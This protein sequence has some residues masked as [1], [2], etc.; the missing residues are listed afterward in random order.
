MGYQHRVLKSTCGHCKKTF[1]WVDRELRRFPQQWTCKQCGAINSQKLPD[2]KPNVPPFLFIGPE[3]LARFKVYAT[4]PEH[5]NIAAEW[6]PPWSIRSF[7]KQASG[8]FQGC[9]FWSQ[10]R[11]TVLGEPVFRDTCRP[12]DS[13]IDHDDEGND[14]HLVSGWST[15]IDTCPLW[16]R[17]KKLCQTD[18]EQRFFH[19]YL[20]FVKDRQFPMLIPQARIGVAERRRPDF[21]LFVPLQQLNYRWL[22]IELDGAH[23][24]T[25]AEEDAQRNADLAAQGYSVFPVRPT[26]RGYMEEVRR[27]VERVE[28]EMELAETDL[29]KVALE[30]QAI[31]TTPPSDIPF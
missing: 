20:R 21:V 14:C 6:A 18:V 19:H 12:H 23:P 27:L 28:A 1:G 30:A 29:W 5:S 11:G 17:I 9:H 31:R 13:D 26:E 22:A 10:R 15:G 7:V 3:K 16:E 24:E 25:K 2:E 8:K 4:P